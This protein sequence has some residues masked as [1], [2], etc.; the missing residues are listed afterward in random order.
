MMSHVF[1]RSEQDVCECDGGFVWV[2]RGSDD[3]IVETGSN[4]EFFFRWR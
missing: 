2:D 1:V 3:Q 4:K